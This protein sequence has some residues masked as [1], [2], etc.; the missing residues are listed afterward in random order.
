M[1]GETR[2]PARKRGEVA[3]VGKTGEIKER[4]NSNLL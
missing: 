4:P 3:K 1:E 2:R